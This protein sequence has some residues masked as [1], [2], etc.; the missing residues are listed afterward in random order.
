[1]VIG[2]SRRKAFEELTRSGLRWV[3]FVPYV[4]ATAGNIITDGYG[5][6]RLRIGYNLSRDWNQIG[7]APR[8]VV[9]GDRRGRTDPPNLELYVVV[10][11]QG[12]GL[13]YNAFIDA[14][15][16]HVLDRKYF[17]ADGGVG[18]GFR[19]KRFSANYRVAVVS[20]EYDE[21]LVHDYKALRF[22]YAFR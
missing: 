17:V 5:G 20:P 4:G 22:S 12:R 7:I 2:H 6:G 10:D 16:N 18:V 15:P 8:V 13:A 11:G 9:R 1:M 14:A 3:E 21:A 19:F